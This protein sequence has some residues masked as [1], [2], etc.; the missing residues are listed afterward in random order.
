[1][2]L[3]LLMNGVKLE[4]HIKDFHL[5]KYR[6]DIKIITNGSEADH[7]KRFAC[8]YAAIYLPKQVIAENTGLQALQCG[9]PLIT[10]ESAD[11]ASFYGDAALYSPPGEK[12]IAENMMVLYKD[13]TVRKEQIKKGTEISNCYSW[14]AASAA[15]WQLISAS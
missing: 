11:A 12:A 8:A 1:M 4:D 13:E 15:V 2:Q 9:I 7:A 14:K 5:Y 6:D 3:M 10:I